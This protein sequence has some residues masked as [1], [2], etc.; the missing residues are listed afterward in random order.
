MQQHYYG[1]LLD[2]RTCIH[3]LRF[4]LT[5][6]IASGNRA[7]INKVLLLLIKSPTAVLLT[8]VRCFLTARLQDII[9]KVV[10]GHTYPGDSA[11]AACRRVYAYG[12]YNCVP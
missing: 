12:L 7:Y 1:P 10:N 6:D 3:G 8:W 5:D 4:P 9:N 11:V 2:G